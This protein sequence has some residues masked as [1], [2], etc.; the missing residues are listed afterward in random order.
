MRRVICLFL[1]FALIL[2]FT[3]CRQEEETKT[4]D[5]YYLRQKDS[6]VYGADDG[7]IARESRDCSG[8]TSDIRYL[9]TLYL[10]G[11]VSEDLRSPFPSGCVLENIKYDRGMMTLVISGPLSNLEGLN[12]S[13]VCV[14]LAKTCF[15]LTQAQSVQIQVRTSTDKTVTLNTISRADLIPDPASENNS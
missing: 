6:F 14:C 3:G 1:C 10:Q 8:H 4:V 15:S 9:L 12:K 2:P 7:V 13:L 5:F 11:P